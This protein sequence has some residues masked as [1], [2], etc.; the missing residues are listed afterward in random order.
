MRCRIREDL[1]RRVNEESGKENVAIT[2]ADGPIL[3]TVLYCCV[4]GEEMR[5]A[6][7]FNPHRAG[8]NEEQQG[9]DGQ[10]IQE[11]V[12]LSSF[13]NHNGTAL[14]TSLRCCPKVVST[15]LAD[16]RPPT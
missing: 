16:V 2:E 13:P 10:D 4:N 1:A 9:Q 8:H 15:F 7:A 6:I 14:W 12:Q 3:P 5:M 11:A